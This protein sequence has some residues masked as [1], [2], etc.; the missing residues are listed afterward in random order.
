MS[1][2]YCQEFCDSSP[3]VERRGFEELQKKH[4]QKNEKRIREAI[5]KSLKPQQYEGSN[6]PRLE[7]IYVGG[8]RF[9]ILRFADGSWCT[10]TSVGKKDPKSITGLFNKN[11]CCSL[12]AMFMAN[13]NVMNLMGITSPFDLRKKLIER[14][15]IFPAPGQMLDG[16]F[17]AKVAKLLGFNVD[18]RFITKPEQNVNMSDPTRP[19]L[20]PIFLHGN[21][22]LVPGLDTFPENGKKYLDGSSEL[23]RKVS[24][25]K[26]IP[27]EEDRWACTSCTFLNNVLMTHCEVCKSKKSF[28]SSSSFSCSSHSR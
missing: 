17:I 11:P 27:Q 2:P 13:Q 6:L 20:A 28:S 10:N 5:Q 15:V 1:C 26:E 22:Y 12:N 14:E 25:K 18:I 8:V 16:R 21:H 3:C 7:T 9:L 4:E 19:T 23:E 24:S